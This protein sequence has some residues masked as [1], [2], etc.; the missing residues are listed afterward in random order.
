[1]IDLESP[2]TLLGTWNLARTI[3]D[4]RLGE[5]GTLTG[6]LDLT[7]EQP[8]RIRW[9]ERATWHRTGGDVAVSRRLRLERADHGWW[10]RFEDG[11]EFHP[12]AP[13]EPVV[14]D[15]APD[16]YRGQVSGTPDGWS[17]TW[18]VTGPEKD[19]TMTTLLT[20]P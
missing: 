18:E 7:E 13:G 10:M 8:G 2:E 19:Y 3:E 9:E 6:V 16:T 11:R 5:E 1:V 4:R 12:W 14:H 20:P 17:V 15:C